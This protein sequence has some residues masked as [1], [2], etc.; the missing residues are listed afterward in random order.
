MSQS[1][2]A[3]LAQLRKLCR[4]RPNNRSLHQV[5][6]LLVARAHGAAGPPLGA[7]LGGNSGWLAADDGKQLAAMLQQLLRASAS[8]APLRSAATARRRT[9]RA[10]LGS[11]HGCG[12]Y[13]GGG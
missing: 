12:E 3:T 5:L 1:Q 8:E 4:E 11:E 10:Q 7:A 2:F 13:E 9:A 6:R